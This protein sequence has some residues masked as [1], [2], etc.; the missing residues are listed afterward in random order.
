MPHID[1]F[2][3]NLWRKVIENGH[4]LVVPAPFGLAIDFFGQRLQVHRVNGKYPKINL[5]STRHVGEMH[6][7][8]HLVRL[9][10]SGHG[11]GM[12]TPF[13]SLSAEAMVDWD[14][15]KVKGFEPHIDFMYGTTDKG[16]NPNY[17]EQTYWDFE[18]RFKV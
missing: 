1:I 3:R 8:V 5:F 13:L 6:S 14:G 18:K 2:N 17:N 16:V 7:K 11:Y 4:Y 15:N 12:N 10:I 9:D